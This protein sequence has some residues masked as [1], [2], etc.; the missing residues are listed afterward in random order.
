MGF[1]SFMI[2]GLM[3]TLGILI[4][5]LFPEQQIGVLIRNYAGIPVYLLSELVQNLMKNMGNNRV[6]ARI[7]LKYSND[8]DNS[9]K[10]NVFDISDI[11]SIEEFLD[12]KFIYSQT[13]YEL[14]NK[15]IYIN[16]SLLDEVYNKLDKNYKQTKF[17]G[18]LLGDIGTGKTTLINE[19]LLL[20][21]HMK[22]LT[23]T[24][25]GESITVGPPI[26]YNNPNYL[27]WLV[28][29]DTQGFDKDTDF[30]KSIDNMKQFIEN[31]FNENDTNEFVNF[32]IYCING[33]RF[34]ESEKKNIIMLRNL[35]P[36]SKLQ[37][38]VVNTRGLNANAES[39]LNKIK[40]DMEKNYNINDIIYIPISAIKS[41]IYNPMT[42][43]IDE[44]G[45]YNMNK[46]LETIINITENSLSSTIY[47]L[48]L[49]KLK[50]LHKNNMDNIINK[51]GE[52]N[53]TEF[54]ANY[55]MVI[56]KCLKINVDKS[57]LNTM[58]THYFKVSEKNKSG[59]N[60][61]DN[62][63]K[64]KDEY[65]KEGGKEGL[66]KDTI[67]NYRNIYIEKVSQKSIEGLLVLMKKLMC[68][69]FIFKDIIDHLE[70]SHRIKF[71]VDNIVKNFKKSIKAK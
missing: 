43:K 55:K 7:L 10:E 30:I 3:I 59:K 45:T 70:K 68:E 37:I 50:K 28:L 40:H 54:D 6:A 24:I 38:I 21:N 26:R 17:S 57:I 31:Q 20:P 9:I 65:D 22:G 19:F 27:P 15:K 23:E 8:I 53:I 4:Q 69:N 34:I 49:E 36:A 33:E 64:M 41:G 1:L 61:E 14:M 66:D 32:I 63:R 11:S 51:I 48:Y 18:L 39:L 52:K 13:E 58:Q 16:E 71:Y 25:A 2:S 44:Y 5:T 12:Y 35:Y 60:I 67:E 47:K 29:Y 62:I 46:L 56:E 42:K